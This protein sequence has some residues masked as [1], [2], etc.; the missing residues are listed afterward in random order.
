MRRREQGN[1]RRRRPKQTAIPSSAEVASL[2]ESASRCV[3]SIRRMT[4]RS[5]CE[6][7]AALDQKACFWTLAPA[8]RPSKHVLSTFYYL[9]VRLLGEI[10]Q[11]LLQALKLAESPAPATS[12]MP[13]RC[14]RNGAMPRTVSVKRTPAASLDGPAARGD[15]D[16]ISGRNAYRAGTE[17]GMLHRDSDTGPRTAPGDLRRLT[18]AACHSA[19]CMD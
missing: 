8:L 3:I 14:C 15:A 1:S 18:D 9:C 5:R 4:V 16:T 7:R 12:A 11:G 13:L 19:A 6:T 2:K 17:G 10:L